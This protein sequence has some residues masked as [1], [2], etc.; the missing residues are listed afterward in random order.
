MP[1]L[2]LSFL[3]SDVLS[4]LAHSWLEYCD[5]CP[6]GM[7]SCH[8][9]TCSERFGVNKVCLCPTFSQLCFFLVASLLWLP[10]F[11][12]RYE[13]RKGSC[14]ISDSR[15]ESKGGVVYSHVVPRPLKCT[16]PAMRKATP[17]Y[18]DLCR[19]PRPLLMLRRCAR[20]R[21]PTKT[22]VVYRAHS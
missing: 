18:R 19:L 10:L 17:T 11:L 8:L 9:L 20:P 7:T 2:H 22:C 21:P 13:G 6:G 16:A 4:L 14:R 12:L 5:T 3:M 1:H 15:A